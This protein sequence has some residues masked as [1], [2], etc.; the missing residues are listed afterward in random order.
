MREIAKKCLRNKLIE[1]TIL[2]ENR[3]DEL[4]D[5]KISDVIDYCEDL[6]GDHKK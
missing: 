1:L 2:G 4:Y 6:I 3:E 5:E